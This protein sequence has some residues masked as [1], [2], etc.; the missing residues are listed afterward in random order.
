[1]SQRAHVPFAPWVG[2]GALAPAGAPHPSTGQLLVAAEGA[3]DECTT[4]P[5]ASPEFLRHPAGPRAVGG[6]TVRR[7]RATARPPFRTARRPDLSLRGGPRRRPRRRPRRARPPVPCPQPLVP[8]PLHRVPRALGRGGP[9]RRRTTRTPVTGVP[10]APVRV[11]GRPRGCGQAGGKRV[12]RSCGC[13][14]FRVLNSLLPRPLA[15]SPSD[16]QPRRAGPAT[17]RAPDRRDHVRA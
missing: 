7:R 2:P 6:L 12:R 17:P 8:R 14:E 11:S 15:L 13:T 3:A 4:R 9:G 10:P 5:A 16:I 1:V